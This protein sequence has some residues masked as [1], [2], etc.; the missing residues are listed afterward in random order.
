M[1]CQSFLWITA[2]YFLLIL[3]SE[4]I[5]SLHF[6]RFLS[7]EITCQSVF[8]LL[9]LSL[10]RFHCDKL[11]S[12][13]NTSDFLISTNPSSMASK[14][15]I[16]L[17]SGTCRKVQSFLSFLHCF[18]SIQKHYHMLLKCPLVIKIIKES[19]MKILKKLEICRFGINLEDEFT[20]LLYYSSHIL[21]WTKSPTLPYPLKHTKVQCLISE[22]L[23]SS[24][25]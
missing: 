12:H 21:Q 23:K 1:Q 2:F 20:F 8:I 6:P 14:N 7:C 19:M 10:S 13:I 5:F 17:D 3:H 16:S 22:M 4:F 18:K 15:P 24:C 9:C 25:W 11:F